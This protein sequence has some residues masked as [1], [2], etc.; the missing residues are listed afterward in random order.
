MKKNLRQVVISLL[1]MCAVSSTLS[2]TF[3]HAQS[4]IR[5]R[6]TAAVD[7]EI[8]IAIRANGEIK[9][10][11]L[12]G[13]WVNDIERRV[14]YVVTSQ[15]IEIEGDVLEIDCHKVN[16]TS[17][18]VS[19]C[20]SLETLVCYDNK[21]ESLNIASNKALKKIDI[22]KNK[23]RA[24]DLTHAPLLE[25]LECDENPIEVLDVTRNP[26][27]IRLKASQCL[28]GK[29][30]LSNNTDLEAVWCDLNKISSLEV[31]NKAK[32]HTLWCDNNKL[33]KLDIVNCPLLRL[34]GCNTNQLQTLNIQKS[35]AIEKLWCHEN[36]LNQLDVSEL[37]KLTLLY[38]Q[39]N[40]IST[41]DVTKNTEL[42]RFWLFGNQIRGKAMSRL[43]GSLPSLKGKDLKQDKYD[44][45][46][47]FVVVENKIKEAQNECLTSDIEIL[48]GKMWI[49]YD[50][51]GN[52]PNRIIYAG[53]PV[54]IDHVFS[55]DR[56]TITTTPSGVRLENA[57]ANQAVE[58]Y[59]ANGA[60]VA[61]SRT[62]L[63]GSAEVLLD[64]MP[65]GVCIIRVGDRAIKA[66]F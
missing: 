37:T 54:S 6:T 21:I 13:N 51:N 30:D 9:I 5:M 39:Y 2:L 15:D 53:G 7:S 62:N 23:I 11:G 18:D 4:V 46:G 40:K 16:L 26:K 45:D 17:I 28:I 19:S 63:E 25:R 44:G 1:L 52:Y 32:L 14:R 10:K 34:L 60:L 3:A 35:P 38:C 50:Y 31:A 22:A 27:I 55:T 59:T 47:A 43:V 42:R 36:Q 49:A 64:R 33:T 8:K 66:I 48:E 57:P 41:L 20:P 56:L 29:L 61:I 65:Q 12:Q 58:V 24:L